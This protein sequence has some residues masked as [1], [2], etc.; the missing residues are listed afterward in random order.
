[1]TGLGWCPKCY[2]LLTPSER[3]S[4]SF[5][6]VPVRRGIYFQSQPYPH[7]ASLRCDA[8]IRRF[9]PDG[10]K[11]RYQMH[12]LSIHDPRDFASDL[13]VR[14]TALHAL[15]DDDGR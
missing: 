3:S 11:V 2:V 10:K 13:P 7:L 5:L 15:I 4:Q 6:G 1:M 8:L 14:G 9:G 12:Y